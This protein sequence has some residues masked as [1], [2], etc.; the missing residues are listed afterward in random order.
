MTGEADRH[1]GT[2]DGSGDSAAQDAEA[3]ERATDEGMPEPPDTDSS[4]IAPEDLAPIREPAA[5]R[6]AGADGSVTV[7]DEEDEGGYDLGGEA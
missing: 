1:R 5:A 3:E 4:E 7:D 2:V 6:D